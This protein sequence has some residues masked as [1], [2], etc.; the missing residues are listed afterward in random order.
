[1]CANLNAFQCSADAAVVV[2]PRGR[3]PGPQ[4]SG[5]AAGYQVV[6]WVRKDSNISATT[7]SGQIS[8]TAAFEVIF[9]NN[10]CSETLKNWVMLRDNRV[11]SL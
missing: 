6:S 2:F 8:P 10:C 4:S 9:R 1:M 11:A 3:E 5:Y 7:N